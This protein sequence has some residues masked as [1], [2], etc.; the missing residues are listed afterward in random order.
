VVEPEVVATSPYRI[1]SPVPVC[2][3]I[4]SRKLVLAA[5]CLRTATTHLHWRRSRRRVSAVGLRERQ[6]SLHLVLPQIDFF[7]KEICRLLR[8]G[9]IQD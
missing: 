8:G 6:W 1:K 7:T 3:G 5:G 4:S 2:C 9:E